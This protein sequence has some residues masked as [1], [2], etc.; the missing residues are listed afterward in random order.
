LPAK[1]WWA[2]RRKSS[3][4]ARPMF[5]LM[6]RWGVALSSLPALWSSME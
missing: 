4:I 3:P 1:C 5:V 6:V 2:L